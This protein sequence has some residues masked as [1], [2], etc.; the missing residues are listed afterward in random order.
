M[1]WLCLLPALLAVLLAGGCTTTQER[2]A[3]AALK[4]DKARLEAL[5]KPGMDINAGRTTAL[6]HACCSGSLECVQLLVAKGA[7]INK[8]AGALVAMEKETLN[9]GSSSE[10]TGFAMRGVI[11]PDG[12]VVESWQQS[13]DANGNYV[14]I[15]SKWVPEVG[16]CALSQA[17]VHKHAQIVKYLLE[18]G[19]TLPE[20]LWDQGGWV[21]MGD[22]A[23]R[24]GNA[25]I[26]ELIRQSSQPRPGAG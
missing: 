7:D 17:V 10:R 1:R 2:L 12:Q 3:S 6:M 25:E 20:K 26:I 14:R 18:R 4:G 5:I 23:A 19:A 11:D 22:L 9:R 8:R 13:T 21:T 15:H 24:S 16:H